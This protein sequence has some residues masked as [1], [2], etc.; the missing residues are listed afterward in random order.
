MI[1]I[2][3]LIE[4]ELEGGYN[5][6]SIGE[7]IFTQ[8]DTLTEVKENIKEAIECHFEKDEKPKLIRLSYA[9]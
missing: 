7:S 9:N 4:R 1:E 6:R 2:I 3:F 5:A 8:G